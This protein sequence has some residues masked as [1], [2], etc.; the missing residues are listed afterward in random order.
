MEKGQLDISEEENGLLEFKEQELKTLRHSLNK[1]T[2]S[3]I[4]EELEVLKFSIDLDRI[5][6]KPELIQYIEYMYRHGQLNSDVFEVFRAKAFNLNLDVTDGFFLSFFDDWKFDKTIIKEKVSKWNEENKDS[7]ITL[8]NINEDNRVLIQIS[9]LKE[10]FIFD[11][12]S[13]YSTSYLEEDKAL[14][15]IYFKEKIVYIQTTNVKIFNSIKTVVRKVLMSIFDK[16]KVRLLTPKMQQKLSVT[17]SENENVTV[18]DDRTINPTT[19]KLMDLLFE[20]DNPKSNFNGLECTEITFDHEDTEKRD[21]KSRIDAQSY[22]GG[23]LLAKDDVK[24]LILNNRG[25]ISVEIK[26][27]YNEQIT[28]EDVRI[29]TVIGGLSID[30]LNGLRLYIKNNDFALKRVLEKAYRDLK[31]V[32]IQLYSQNSLRNEEKIKSILGLDI[33][34]KSRK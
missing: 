19:I 4:I 20:L 25:I 7:S 27:Y 1:L 2:Q 24:N 15:E 32:F 23:D 31:S 28:G 6:K 34:G 30:K 12:E 8:K 17:L 14:V 29:H 5:T 11:R 13:M 21:M 3:E 26:I 18:F 9:R 33:N 22:G 10:K 16:E